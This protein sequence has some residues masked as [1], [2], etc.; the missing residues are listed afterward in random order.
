MISAL[1]HVDHRLVRAELRRWLEVDDPSTRLAAVVGLIRLGEDVD[2]SLVDELAGVDEVRNDLF[3]RLRDVGAE[4]RFPDRWHNQRAFA[5]SE[6][7][8]WLA[9]PTELAAAPEGLELVAV[10][11]AGDEAEF[12]MFKFR[13]A[14]NDPWCSGL[15]GPYTPG[16][17]PTT[18]TPGGTFSTFET[19]DD[20]DRAGAAARIIE[21]VTAASE[22]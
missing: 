15:A 3:D 9:F 10:I 20:G 1:G 13:A 6:M 17:A 2:Q 12:Y 5:A 14:A 16:A 7:T 11:A 22:S 19:F 21:T 18:E 8:R 4:A